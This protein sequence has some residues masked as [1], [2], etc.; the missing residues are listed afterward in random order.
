MD[1]QEK[2]TNQYYVDRQNDF[3]SS[4]RSYPRKF[5]FA[6]KKAKGSWVEDVEG[7]KYLDFLCGAG[8]LA[9]GHN[10]DEVN[11]AMVDLLTSDAPLHTLDLTT[12]V[13]DRFVH[14]ILSLLP[15]GLKENAKIQFCSPS[16]TD[17]VDAAIKLCKTATGRSTVIA[18]SGG[19]HG[20]GHG[21][22][23]LTGNLNAKNKVANLMAGVQFMPYPYSYRCPF[24]LGGESGTKAC[25]NYF[26]RLLKDPESGITKPAAVILEPIQGE[27]GV[28][29]A[30]IEF[31]QAVRRITQELDI[32]MIVDEIQCGIGRSGKL[33]A[34]EYAS[35]VP[36]VILASKAI[37]GTQPMSV[38]IYNKKLDKWTAGAHAGTFRGNQLAM[39]AGTVVLNRVSQSEFLADV[40]KKGDYLR[41][42]MNELKDEVSIIGD[43]RGK[44]LMLGVEFIDPNGPKDIMGHP[45]P[46]GE[47]AALVQK[48]CFENRLVMEKGGRNGSVMRCLCALNVSM[49][50]INIMLDIFKKVVKEVD[51][52]RK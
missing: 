42:A 41:K 20:M 35:I 14:T 5:P 19:Y 11:Q 44:G 45:E 52:E 2:N 32:P 46:C 38:V 12:P 3:E 48:K 26:E 47:I 23:A 37:G 40:V 10:D 17:A 39:A 22:L 21:A 43:V 25:I 29:P 49:D 4:A 33:F 18:F 7:N 27:G 30:P 15:E 24:G 9:L 28:V 6:L 8:T 31:L 51:N 1:N 36:D 16:G 34:F 13:K 50:E